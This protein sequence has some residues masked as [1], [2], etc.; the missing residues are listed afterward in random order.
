MKKYKVA[1]I[2]EQGQ[3]MIIIPLEGRTFHTQPAE[4]QGQ[5]KYALQLCAQSAGLAGEVCLVWEHARRLYFIAP[6]PWHPFFKS[7]TMARVRHNLNTELT[8]DL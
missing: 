6:P 5:T 2:Q 7:L 8:C 4:A 1:H 3:D